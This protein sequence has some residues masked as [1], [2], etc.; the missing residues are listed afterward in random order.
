[1]YTKTATSIGRPH[2]KILETVSQEGVDLIV[3]ASHQP[4]FSDYLLGSVAAKVVR[5]AP[6]SV[7]VIR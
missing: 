7:H 2:H 3:I 5:R 4:E 1:M 6:C